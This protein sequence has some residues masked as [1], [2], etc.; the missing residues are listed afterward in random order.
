MRQLILLTI[1]L[2]NGLAF[3]LNAKPLP[4]PPSLQLDPAAN[5]QFGAPELQPALE[6][7]FTSRNCHL[8]MLSWF[9]YDS[10]TGKRL[11][12]TEVRK[13]YPELNEF[14]VSVD[15]SFN[16]TPAEL[17]QA[18]DIKLPQHAGPVFIYLD[19]N[20]HDSLH[21]FLTAEKIAMHQQ[22]V[23]AFGQLQRLPKYFILTPTKGLRPQG[24]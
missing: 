18:L 4:R 15:C 1:I 23:N 5:W 10:R 3:S 11:T 2:I 12:M 24:I 17:E 14:P 21:V 20:S 9:I 13:Q 16:A 8:L 19:F 22:R 6:Q 7:F